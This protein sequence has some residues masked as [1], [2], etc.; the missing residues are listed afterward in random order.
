MLTLFFYLGMT[1]ILMDFAT[2]EILICLSCLGMIVIL[3]D[4]CKKGESPQN[5]KWA[6]DNHCYY[7]IHFELAQ[8]NE[9]LIKW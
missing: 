3:I 8:V 7:Y 2:H 4:F 6:L 1:V 5:W 9:L